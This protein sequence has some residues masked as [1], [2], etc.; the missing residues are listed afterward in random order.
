MGSIRMF[1]MIKTC[2]NWVPETLMTNLRW[3]WSDS[4]TP[5]RILKYSWDVHL[6]HCTHCML[7]NELLEEKSVIV[8]EGGQIRIFL[9]CIP[10]GVSSLGTLYFSRYDRLTILRQ[11]YYARKTLSMVKN[12]VT[13]FVQIKGALNRSRSSL[14]FHSRDAYAKSLTLYNNHSIGGLAGNWW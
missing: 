12:F 10:P 2:R 14:C 3:K 4:C 7:T 13:S 11:L 1:S 6:T 5:G 9:L 8:V